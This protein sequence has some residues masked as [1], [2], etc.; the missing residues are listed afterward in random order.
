M[1]NKEQHPSKENIMYKDP[2][3][4]RSLAIQGTERWPIWLDIM[5]EALRGPKCSGRNWQVSVTPRFAV[6]AWVLLSVQMEA[7]EG[8]KERELK[9]L[10]A[11]ASPLQAGN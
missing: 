3:A 11:G 1:K 10:R 8:L 7:N 9:K 5:R 6:P 4:G 2:E